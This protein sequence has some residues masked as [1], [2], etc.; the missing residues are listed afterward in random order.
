MTHD[1]IIVGSGAAGMRAA[2]EI[3]R[4]APKADI[5]IV[6]KL[7]PTR[8]PSVATHEGLAAALGNVRYDE[9]GVPVIDDEAA[10]LDSWQAHARDTLLAADGL[11]DREAVELLCAEAPSAVYE[12]EHLGLPF[13]RLADGR[14][15]Q[16]VAPGHS[17]P[18]VRLP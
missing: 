7:Y 15:A 9:G 8:A 12:L 6:T 16:R 18:R 1:V 13:S 11:A 2:I 5:A 4:R 10:P 17:Q 14:I 3:R